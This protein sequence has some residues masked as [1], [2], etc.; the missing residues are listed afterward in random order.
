MA[1]RAGRAEKKLDGEYV[2]KI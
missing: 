1:Q 2:P